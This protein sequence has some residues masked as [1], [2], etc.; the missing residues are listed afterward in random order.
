[1][2]ALVS[3]EERFPE[4]VRNA[5]SMPSLP[6][7]AMEIL[8]LTEREDSG[9]DDIATAVGF[10]PALAAKMLKL[11]NSTTYC[12]ASEVTTIQRAAMAAPSPPFR[13]CEPLENRLFADG[14]ESGDTSA[15]SATVP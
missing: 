2:T 5:D 11:A 9:L 8:R 3:L 7:V 15:W 12:T 13:L 1:M 4:I 14:F 10:D 6:G